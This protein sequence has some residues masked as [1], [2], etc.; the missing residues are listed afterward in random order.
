LET[1][2]ASY[3]PLTA[4]FTNNNILYSIVSFMAG[5]AIPVGAFIQLPPGNGPAATS[6]ESNTMNFTSLLTIHGAGDLATA[7]V[8]MSRFDT[9]YL[10]L[11]VEVSRS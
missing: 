5:Q 10:S 3:P 8:L 2:I 6:A 1:D 11:I 4:D 9:K 7:K